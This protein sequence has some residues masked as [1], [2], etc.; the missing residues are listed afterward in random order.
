MAQPHFSLRD[1]E[2]IHK[3]IDLILDSQLSMGHNVKK[4]EE[5]FAC[6][7]G[8]K[9]AIA[10]NSC[11]SALESALQYYDVRGR[12]VIVPVETFIATG[13]SIHLSGG[14]PIFS[15]IS[16]DTFS[17][18]FDDMKRR[19]NSNT[20]GIILVHMGGTISPDVKKFRNFCDEN[21]LFLIEDAAHAP[22]AKL[23][24][25]FAGNIGHLGCFSFYPTKVITSAEGGM[26]TTNDVDIA[27][28]A[29]SFQ[30]RGRDMNSSQEIFSMP[31][32]NVRMTEFQALIGQIQLSYLDAYLDRRRQIAKIYIEEFKNLKGVESIAPK[33]LESSSFWKFILL[34]DKSIDRVFIY[35]YMK[36]QGVATDWAYFPALHLQPVF[37]ELYDTCAGQLPFSEDYLSRHICLPCHPGLSDDE[38]FHVTKSLIDALKIIKENT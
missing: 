24:G 4:F 26:L 16:K 1:R 18:D 27:N 3:E 34:L 11:T 8:V 5:S 15:E 17:L 38:A 14:I 29:R 31:G 30:N 7:V 32:R 2:I 33:Q 19:V 23:D 12:E 10:M 20:A 22:G 36:S 13:M 21:G 9:Y 37:R 6:K 25:K 28:Y 35:D